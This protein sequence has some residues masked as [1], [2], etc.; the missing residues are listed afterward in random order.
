MNATDKERFL[1]PLAFVF[2]IATIGWGLYVTLGA[3]LWF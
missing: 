2:F 1:Q 3:L